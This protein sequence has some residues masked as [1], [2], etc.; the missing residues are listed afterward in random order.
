MEKVN[1][2]FSYSSFINRLL[3]PAAHFH[4]IWDGDIIIHRGGYPPLA[5]GSPISKLVIMNLEAQSKENFPASSLAALYPEAFA[6]AMM[7]YSRSGLALK[8][9]ANEGLKAAAIEDQVVCQDNKLSDSVAP[10]NW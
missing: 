9:S 10:S 7:F 6:L 3:F 2:A 1:E 4:L 5:E 8:R